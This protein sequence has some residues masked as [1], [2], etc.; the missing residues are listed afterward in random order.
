MRSLPKHLLLILLVTPFP[1]H[2][3][4]LE[5]L[6]KLTLIMRVDGVIQPFG[7]YTQSQCFTQVD[8]QDPGKLFTEDVDSACNF[9]NKRY[10]ANMYTFNLRCNNIDIGGTG[11]VEYGRDKFVG[12]MTV[13]AKKKGGPLVES[14]SEI[15]G[16]RVGPC[17]KQ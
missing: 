13:S 3:E 14:I 15:T 4:V 11:E 7:P 5:G 12:H 6:W 1:V 2:A 9:T 16:K 17:Q 8:I 10:F